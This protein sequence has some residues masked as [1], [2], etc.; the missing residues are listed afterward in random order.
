MPS[1]PSRTSPEH[2]QKNRPAVFFRNS[3]I[4]DT[5]IRSVDGEHFHVHADILSSAIPCFADM[6]SLPQPSSS[7]DSPPSD[8]EVLNN[9]KKKRVILTQESSTVWT[10]F[11]PLCYLPNFRP[12]ALPANLTLV[13]DFLAAADKFE[14]RAATDW[15]S[16]SLLGRCPLLKAH[17]L[18]VYAL[19]W[20]YKLPEVAR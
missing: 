4:G 2:T 9:S 18:S 11:I 19:A 5:I 10:T 13:R 12:P 20:A 14:L 16:A 7:A 1:N 3:A 15:V 6:L 8:S 17:P